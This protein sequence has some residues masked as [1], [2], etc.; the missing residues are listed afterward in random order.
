MEV[1][2]LASLV[3]ALLMVFAVQ[4]YAW[5][6]D[7][8]GAMPVYST[9]NVTR[10]HVALRAPDGTAYANPTNAAGLG[11]LAARYQGGRGEGRH[12][13][14]GEG[15]HFRGDGNT[16]SF[17]RFEG[18][19]FFRHRFF[20]DDDFPRYYYYSCPWGSYYSPVYGCCIPYNY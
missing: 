13:R 10:T 15:M 16:R 3:L 18:L 20:D 11:L 19:R 5:A 9:V 7:H 8:N 17:D 4:E 12:F 2:I 14:G 1:K 6:A